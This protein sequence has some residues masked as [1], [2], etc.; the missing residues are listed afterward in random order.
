[1]ME[2]VWIGIVVLFLIGVLVALLHIT[3]NNKLKKRFSNN[4]LIKDLVRSLTQAMMEKINEPISSETEPFKVVMETVRVFED[5]IISFGGSVFFNHE[6]MRLLR[7]VM[8]RKM[9]ARAITEQLKG[10]IVKEITQCDPVKSK[11]YNLKIQCQ[12]LHDGSLSC[13]Q[14]CIFYATPNE[15]YIQA[16][17]W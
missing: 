4:A 17:Q 12:K 7:T 3:F 11:E 15:H 5:S 10:S 13:F 6:H 16:K 1:M 14:V 9:M 2:A 8:E